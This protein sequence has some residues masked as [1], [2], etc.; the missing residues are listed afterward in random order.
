MNSTGI[1]KD[2]LQVKQVSQSL[3]QNNVERGLAG[4]ISER[5]VRSRTFSMADLDG[6]IGGGLIRVAGIL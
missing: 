4:P 5:Q 6:S 3:D 2:I 1:C